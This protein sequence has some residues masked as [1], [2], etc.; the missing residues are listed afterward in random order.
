M[1]EFDLSKI[2]DKDARL[3]KRKQLL[4]Y[5][6][7]PAVILGLISIKLL[8][9]IVINANFNSL[10]NA[11]KYD[12]AASRVG[13]N[14]IL[15]IIQPYKVYF[16]QGNA[17]FR[18]NKLSEAEK[19]YERALDLVADGK[20]M[21]AVRFNLSA[22]IEAQGDEAVTAKDFSKAKG[23][24]NKATLTLN[25]GTKCFESQEP[26]QQEQQQQS[27]DQQ[28]EQKE[29]KTGDA[30]SDQQKELEE[31]QKDAGD[32]ASKGDGKE[33]EQEQQESNNNEQSKSPSKDKQNKVEGEQGSTSGNV[34]DDQDRDES[35]SGSGGSDGSDNFYDGPRY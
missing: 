35:Q 8:G 26:K 28:K 12:A 11:G 25:A 13:L 4:K 29:Q 9:M 7:A 32:K 22:T 30:Y 33:Q 17:Q 10:Y 20:D 18:A 15:N 1:G 23:L 16:N 21:C 34:Q 27:G 5:S 6:I 14:K 2:D 31:K 24:Y 3:I 19:S